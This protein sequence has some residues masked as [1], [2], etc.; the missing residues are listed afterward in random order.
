MESLS[1]RLGRK[2]LEASH[3]TKAY[4]GKT[5]ISDFSYI[6]LPRDRIGLVGKNGSG[7]STLLKLLCGQITPDSGSVV[8]GETVKIGYFSQE[9]E[10]LDP[11]QR[12]I[13][14]VR[15]IAEDVHQASV[16]TASQM[17]ERFLFPGEL[18]TA[19]W[20][21]S[22]EKAT[23]AAVVCIDGQPGIFVFG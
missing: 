23:A 1:T 4:D 19:G 18:H 7:K 13:D 5:V 10:E 17:L 12:V 8:L 16:I 9:S 6:V 11:K 3:V 2:T 14:V 15:E 20:K 21:S 22:A